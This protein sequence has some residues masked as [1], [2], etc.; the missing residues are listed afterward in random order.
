LGRYHHEGKIKQKRG[1][2][3]IDGDHRPQ[4]LRNVVSDCRRPKGLKGRIH[5]EWGKKKKLLESERKH[6]VEKI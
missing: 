3:E 5:R 2:I 1:K 4:K 6:V